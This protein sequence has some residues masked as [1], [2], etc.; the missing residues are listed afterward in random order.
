MRRKKIKIAMYNIVSGQ[1]NWLKAALCMMV[2]LNIDVAFLMEAKITYAAYTWFNHG[3]NVT[4]TQR[5]KYAQLLLYYTVLVLIYVI[6]VFRFHNSIESADG[7]N[8]IGITFNKIGDTT[9]IQQD[10]ITLDGAIQPRTTSW[11]SKIKL[12]TG[13]WKEQ[14]TDFEMA[15]ESEDKE[16]QFEESAEFMDTENNRTTS[17]LAIKATK[18]SASDHTNSYQDYDTPNMQVK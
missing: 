3:L 10:W 11:S 12:L 1:D 8:T 2:S 15:L 7:R 18:K 4:A 16:D 17:Q 9:T 5:S 13:K 6:F 14:V